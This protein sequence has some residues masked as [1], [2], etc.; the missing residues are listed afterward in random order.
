[1]KYQWLAF[2]LNIEIVSYFVK[3]D[4]IPN[5]VFAKF[6]L[7]QCSVDCPMQF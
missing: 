6:K 1:M 5:F 4:G 2:K 7:I 3:H